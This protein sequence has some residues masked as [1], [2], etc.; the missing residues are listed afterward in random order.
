MLT[1]NDYPEEA[2]FT[3]SYSSVRVE[4][5]SIG[6]VFCV[7]FETTVQVLTERRM[8]MLQV[9]GCLPATARTSAQVSVESI[10]NNCL[11]TTTSKRFVETRSAYSQEVQQIFRLL[12]YTC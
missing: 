11:L 9:L 4:G 5:G 3:L 6:G 12:F 10:S 8:R 2:Y 1:R 7:V